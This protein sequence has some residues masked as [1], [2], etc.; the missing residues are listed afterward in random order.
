[1]LRPLPFPLG[2]APGCVCVGAPCDCAGPPSG[3]DRLVKAAGVMKYMAIGVGV[4]FAISVL[5]QRK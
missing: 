1:M 3:G 5:A 4:L 2:D